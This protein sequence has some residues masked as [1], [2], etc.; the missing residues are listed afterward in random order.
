MGRTNH[1]IRDINTNQI[2]SEPKE[3]ETTFMNQYK[4][5]ERFYRKIEL[6]SPITREEIQKAVNKLKTGKSP[7]S[8]GLP[9]EWY[10][11]FSQQLIPL[12][13][14][15]VNYT[16][17]Y[18]EIP[19]SWKEAV[20]SVIPKKNNSKT[21][22]DYRPISLL[23]IDYKL[24]TSIIYKRYEHFISD[25]EEDRTGFIRGRQTQDNIRR[26]L[27]IMDHIQNENISAA[28]ISLDVEKAYDSVNWTFLYLVLKQ[29]RLDDKAAECIKM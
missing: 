29:F 6:N 10:K 4:P 27:H 19:L 13:V 9:S 15:S 22:S 3:I 24:Y 14:L 28:L 8:D 21:C 11:T 25:S 7:S 17:D 26:T 5:N 12:L 20:M 1:R 18:G 16:L 2:I 23:N